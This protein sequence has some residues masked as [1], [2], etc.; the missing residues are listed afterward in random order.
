MFTAQP[1]VVATATDTPPRITPLRVLRGVYREFGRGLP[2]EPDPLHPPLREYLRDLAELHGV[3]LRA[4]FDLSTA[5]RTTF[6]EMAEALV[7]LLG[8]A[9]RPTDVVALAHQAPDADFRR[10]ATCRLNDLLPGSPMP[11]AVSDQGSA[12]PFT[13]LRLAAAYLSAAAG[14]RRALVLAADQAD[15][16]YDVPLRPEDR[17]AGDAMAALLVEAGPRTGGGPVATSLVSA[18]SVARAVPALLERLAVPL[19]STLVVLGP[20]IDPGA[21]P[22]AAGGTVLVESGMPCTG[23][24]V[25]LLD[26]LVRGGPPP[27]AALLDLA[28]G[29]GVLSLALLDLSG[30]VAETSSGSHVAV[31]T[32]HEECAS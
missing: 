13:A 27:Y 14:P 7:P 17:I 11:F 12:A 25:T 29:Q 16:P 32:E 5:R 15:L 10:S 30:V 21:V 20:G 26:H 4:G 19:R 2:Y 28:P 22:D 9:D 1:P 6:V 8:D 31:S 24:W 3:G 18:G 23:G